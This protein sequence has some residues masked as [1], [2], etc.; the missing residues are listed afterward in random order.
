MLIQ[1]FLREGGHNFCLVN[2]EIL[3]LLWNHNRPRLIC[4]K[5]IVKCFILDSNTWSCCFKNL[6]VRH[7]DLMGVGPGPLGGGASSLNQ[8]QFLTIIGSMSWDSDIQYWN[9]FPVRHSNLKF[10]FKT[11]LPRSTTMCGINVPLVCYTFSVNKSKTDVA[12]DLCLKI[13][14]VNWPAIKTIKPR[15]VRV[16]VLK[17]LSSSTYYLSSMFLFLF[18][19]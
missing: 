17:L 12:Q 7:V 11:K 19:P 14:C 15:G 3:F 6:G 4:R 18:Q 10:T 13:L 1:D 8:H 9:C 2:T 5:L 16:K